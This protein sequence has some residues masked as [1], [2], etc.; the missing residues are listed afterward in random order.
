MSVVLCRNLIS[1]RRSR[2]KNTASAGPPPSLLQL[3]P[4]TRIEKRSS[5][6]PRRQLGLKMTNRIGSSSRENQNFPTTGRPP[7]R[8]WMDTKCIRP[9]WM[10]NEAGT[11]WIL[12]FNSRRT[13]MDR[14]LSSQ[15]DGSVT[16][17]T[18]RY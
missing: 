2:R 15:G 6:E 4:V 12:E 13:G 8:N 10:G 11:R 17:M 14:Y 5:N 18:I 9:T 16:R 3:V 1:R 7:D